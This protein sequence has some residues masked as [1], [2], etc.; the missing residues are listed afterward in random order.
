[1]NSNMAFR[2]QT[3][4]GSNRERSHREDIVTYELQMITNHYR[5]V[6]K[7]CSRALNNISNFIYFSRSEKGRKVES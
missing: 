1:M 3:E 2:D 5:M 4:L 7:I 6:L